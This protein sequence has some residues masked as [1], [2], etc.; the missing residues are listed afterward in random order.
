MG[1][2]R[3]I[4]DAFYNLL[5][6]A[7]NYVIAHDR[8]M[9]EKAPYKTCL[10]C[11]RCENNYVYGKQEG[12]RCAVNFGNGKQDSCMQPIVATHEDINNPHYWAPCNTEYFIAYND[13]YNRITQGV[14]DEFSLNELQK[15][16]EIYG[17]GSNPNPN[18]NRYE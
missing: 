17:V 14:E 16:A 7:D 10:Y 12:F 18:L 15:R 1:L 13:G 8:F 11:A 2:F 3:G 5:S 4:A 6:G 9:R